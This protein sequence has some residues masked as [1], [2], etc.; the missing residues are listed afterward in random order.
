MRIDTMAT[1]V[2]LLDAHRAGDLEHILE[3]FA[4]DAFVE[5]NCSNTMIVAGKEGLRAYWV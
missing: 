3:F 5:C 1:A 4:D 2:D